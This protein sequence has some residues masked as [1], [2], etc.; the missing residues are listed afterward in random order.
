MDLRTTQ[1]LETLGRVPAPLL[2]AL[3]EGPAT[4]A[5]LQSSIDDISQSTL[6]RYLHELE[7]AGVV[8]QEPGKPHAPGRNWVVIHVSETEALL[9]AILELAGAIDARSA[10]ERDEALL[11]LKRARARRLGLHQAAG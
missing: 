6:N 5:V 1:L 7:R 4:E 2:L 9:G 11:R 3:M 10:E 8:A